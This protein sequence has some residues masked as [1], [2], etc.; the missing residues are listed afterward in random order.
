M[1][2]ESDLKLVK[3]RHIKT[4]ASDMLEASMIV[5]AG[6]K[7]NWRLIFIQGKSRHKI[8]A[9]HRI[10]TELAN[11]DIASIRRM[12]KTLSELTQ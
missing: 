9:L 6:T 4:L 1:S 2:M 11:A 8:G 12:S 7:R 10:Y 5:E 3:Q